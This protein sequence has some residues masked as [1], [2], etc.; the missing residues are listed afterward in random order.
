MNAVIKPTTEQQPTVWP[1]LQRAIEAVCDLRGDATLNSVALL[2]E[3]HAQPHE[4][5]ADLLAH[6]QDLARLY[7]VALKVP[8]PTQRPAAH[9][10]SEVR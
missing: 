4:I 8:D 6:F 1:Q 9:R 5:Q 3:C 10:A 7:R 2:E